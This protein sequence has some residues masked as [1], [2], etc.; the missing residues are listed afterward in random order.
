MAA[1]ML[2]IGAGVFLGLIGQQWFETT[3]R[4]DEA[5]SSLQRFRAEILTNRQDI[6]AK[7]E[8]HAPMQKALSAFVD[9]DSEGRKAISIKFQ[10]IQPPTFER[11]AWDLA[12]ATQSLTYV[13]PDLAFLLSRA[14]TLQNQVDALTRSFTDS[15]FM[16]P[17]SYESETFLRAVDLYYGD[18][19]EYEPALLQI[20]DKIVPMIDAALGE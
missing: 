20:Y 4:R 11:T 18:L 2:L 9:A 16:N 19:V 13:D 7:L 12:V 6:A 10:G 14:Y 15:M 17:P 5:T 1:E 3:Q 8:Y